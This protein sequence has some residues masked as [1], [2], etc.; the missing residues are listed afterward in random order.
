MKITTIFFFSF[1]FL[2]YLPETTAIDYYINPGDSISS[3]SGKL[4][5]GDTLYI[6]AG[7]YGNDNVRLANSGS[8]NNNIRIIGGPSVWMKTPDGTTISTGKHN[9]IHV[10]GINAIDVNCPFSVKGHH[11]TLKDCSIGHMDN[12]ASIGAGAKDIILDGIELHHTLTTSPNILNVNGGALT[13]ES[14]TE[15]HITRRLTIQNCN[16]HHGKG[17]G[18]INFGPTSTKPGK[19]WFCM[20][21]ITDVTIKDSQIHHIGQGPVA[22]NWITLHRFT[23]ERCKVYDGMSGIKVVVNGGSFKDIEIWHIGV[24]RSCAPFALDIYNGDCNQ[25]VTIQ[26]VYVHDKIQGGWPAL[27]IGKHKRITVSNIKRDSDFPTSVRFRSGSIND[28]IVY[29]MVDGSTILLAKNI[30]ASIRYSDN[31]DFV[32]EGNCD[33]SSIIQHDDYSEIIVTK[34]GGPGIVTIKTSSP[35]PNDFEIPE[36]TPRPVPDYTDIPIE[37]VPTEQNDEIMEEPTQTPG[38]TSYPIFEQIDTIELN[39]FG[40][41]NYSASPDWEYIGIINSNVVRHYYYWDDYLTS[42]E[43]SHNIY[44]P[45]YFGLPNDTNLS[46]GGGPIQWTYLRIIGPK[47]AVRYNN[48]T[49]SNSSDVVYEVGYLPR[50]KRTLDGVTIDSVTASE[51]YH[52]INAFGDD[53]L[54]VNITCEWHKSKRRSYGGIK[55]TYYTTILY[56]KT[57]NTIT[58]WENVDEYNE[59]VEC[60]ITNH[61]GFYNTINMTGLPDNASHYNISVKM[62]NVTKYLLKSSYIYFKNDTVNYQL[63]DMYDYD[64]YDLYGVSPYGKDVFLLPGGRIDNVSIVVNSPFESYELKTNITRIDIIKTTFDGDIYAAIMCFFVAYVLYR[65]FFKW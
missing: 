48:I 11:V 38:P 63:Y 14:T 15:A 31:R 47:H 56:Q 58:Q 19:K 54:T 41:Q 50:P 64:F 7:D 24:S 37:P 36:Y 44:N 27:D 17:H 18:G 42:K 46:M 32:V 52:D 1:L 61:S 30:K 23:M 25:D 3:A 13:A 39:E 40:Y 34:K 35:P 29:N 9:F 8:A 51:L 49:F 43:N 60:V 57:R 59:T 21:L 16:F 28:N 5:A 4:V 20:E 62:G 12:A 45:L 53:M 33:T 26:N 10:E 22:C 65:M 2:F 55:K 6:G